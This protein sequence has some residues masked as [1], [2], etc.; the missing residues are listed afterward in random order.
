[1]ADEWEDRVDVVTRGLQGLTVACARCHDHKFDPIATEDYYALAGVFAGTEMFNRP[2]SDTDDKE[3]NGNAKNPYK[4]LHIIRDTKPKDLPVMIR[5][6]VN[7]KGDVVPRGFIQVVLPGPRRA[8]ESGSG[9]AE[10]ADSITDPSNPLTARVFVN[11]VWQQYFGTG[12]VAT[13]SNFGTLGE[14]PSNQILLDDLAVGFVNSGWSIKWLHRQILLSKAYQRSSAHTPQ[15]AAIDP[16]NAMLWRMPRRRLS[17]E[18][19][20]D[21]VL[22]IAGQ[23]SDQIGGPSIKPDD[24][25]Q[26]RRTIYSEVSRFELN[27]MLSLFDF[28]DPNTHSARRQE[29]NTPLQKL[30]LMNS[31]F[32]VVQSQNIVD[33]TTSAGA[34]ASPDQAEQVQ[35]LFRKILLRSAEPQEAQAADGF[36]MEHPQDGL[37]QLAQVLLSS[38]EF[39]F[40]D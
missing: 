23:L 29:T 7:N 37:Q 3:K 20:R 2:M 19:W 22:L 13:N 24:P 32:M 8:F 36:L 4:S 40:V 18:G 27:P 11:R 35:A 6:D 1:M 25:K 9:R 38:N 14:R 39:W 26:T 21:A 15:A 28:P 16:V 12:I 30:F 34:S 31:D 10:L 33:S 17:V 5:G